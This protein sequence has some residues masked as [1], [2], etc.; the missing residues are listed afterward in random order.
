MTI[1][2]MQVL[3]KS[4]RKDKEFL[5]ER[6]RTKATSCISKKYLSDLAYK[7]DTARCD[8][9]MAIHT[10]TVTNV[11]I[12]RRKRFSDDE[13][14]RR[15]AEAQPKW[16]SHEIK[17]LRDS[18]NRHLKSANSVE[19][20]P[21]A[22]EAC[23]KLAHFVGLLPD[24]LKKNY[25]IARAFKTVRL[26]ELPYFA[27]VKDIDPE[28]DRNRRKWFL[29]AGFISKVIRDRDH[30]STY[31]NGKWRTDPR[32]SHLYQ[33]RSFVVLTDA[34]HAEACVGKHFKQWTAP[35]GYA[36]GIDENGVK[37]FR[38]DSP[39][40]DYHINAEDVLSSSRPSLVEILEGNRQ[41]RLQTEA[42]NR[43]VEAEAEGVWVCLKDSLRAGNCRTGTESFA[44][45]YGFDVRKHYPAKEV[46]NRA[47][48]DYGRARLAISA[49]IS[50]HRR[51]MEVGYADLENH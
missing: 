44:V 27:D 9:L 10:K 42:E 40:D 6:I 45:K 47:N 22:V 50:R 8:R 49:A 32:A 35:D 29:S 11:W 51:E 24:A 21:I 23:N 41:R 34:E 28:F 16:A 37:L 7:F 43:A 30:S 3:W 26:L 18:A 5:R 33:V 13:R 17:L 14:W 15:R 19:R 46:L 12:P 31:R 1:P 39:K 38:K 4:L 36:F 48:G 25:K 20:V 2:E